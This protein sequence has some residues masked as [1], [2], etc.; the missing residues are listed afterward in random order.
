M[1]NKIILSFL[2]ILT[3]CKN[4]YESPIFYFHNVSDR[5]LLNINCFYKNKNFKFDELGIDSIKIY[6]FQI[7]NNDEFFGKM[8]CQMKNFKNKNKK[9]KFEITKNDI[10]LKKKKD[11]HTKPWMMPIYFILSV[12]S[13]IGFGGRDI[14]FNF[15]H[16]NIYLSQDGYEILFSGDKNYFQKN[17][18]YMDIMKQNS[19][20]YTKDEILN[21]NLNY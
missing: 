15:P 11:I 21:K 19:L 12:I 3:N 7:F 1:K 4:S 2:I 13:P 17:F 5:P 18:A 16:V 20:N 6:F 14:E 8:Y 10:V 9:F